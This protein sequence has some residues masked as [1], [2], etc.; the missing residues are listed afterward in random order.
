[1]QDMLRQMYTQLDSTLIVQ[2]ITGGVGLI[3]SA[4]DTGDS[5]TTAS[6]TV[7]YGDI[8][9]AASRSATAVRGVTIPDFV[10]MH[11]RR[12]Y[13][14]QAGLVSVWPLIGGS[15]GN[16][17]GQSV[18]QNYPAAV[19]GRL[20]CGLDVIVDANM[21]TTGEKLVVGP[22]SEVHL[23]E[24]SGNPVFI[25]A[26]QPQAA[27]LGVQLV[28]YEYAAYTLGRYA[29]AFQSVSGTTLMAAPSG[30]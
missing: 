23:W 12:W 7:L 16:S 11:P 26:E 15:V 27:Q 6:Q 30:F 22:R 17:T 14:M 13:W 5:T 20:P 29:N 19:S 3:Q 18:T 1:M 9:G 2:N 21:P 8:I 25:R 24:D 28:V 4:T 10:V